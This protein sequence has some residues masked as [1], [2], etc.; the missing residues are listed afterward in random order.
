MWGVN[1]FCGWA[2]MDLHCLDGGFAEVEA[3][4]VTVLGEHREPRLQHS[5]L[6]EPIRPVG[7]PTCA[8]GFE[9]QPS[10]QRQDQG[11]ARPGTGAHASRPAEPPEDWRHHSQ[12]MKKAPFG[13]FF[14]CMAGPFNCALAT[15]QAVPQ[16]WTSGNLS[17][18]HPATVPLCFFPASN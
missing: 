5:S 12:V 13:R 14:V 16:K 6:N 17:L 18:P 2:R 10:S 9:G 7:G 3:N 4:Q 8:T 11:P 1:A 15:D